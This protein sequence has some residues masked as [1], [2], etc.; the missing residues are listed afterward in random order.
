MHKK[1]L[2]AWRLLAVLTLC[3]FSLTGYAAREED[4]DEMDE[5]TAEELQIEDIPVDERI[6]LVKWNN[7]PYDTRYF[8]YSDEQIKEKWEYLMRGLKMP[9]PSPAY[10]K[11][12]FARY[13]F[14][15]EGIKD[16]DG[17]FNK[18][19]KRYVE[20]W[21][22]FFAGDFQ[23]A[24]NEGLEL[25]TLGLIPSMFSQLMYAIYLTEPSL[26]APW[27]SPAKNLRQTS[28]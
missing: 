17:D 25:G 14:L 28:T 15:K 24:R 18:L 20:V 27:K 19:E 8:T 13:P 16:F 4:D 9:Y 2:P 5:V 21:R 23:G 11:K 12:M 26:R 10:L 3:L 6:F 7:V 22:K 1:E